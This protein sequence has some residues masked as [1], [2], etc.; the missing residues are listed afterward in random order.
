[1]MISQACFFSGTWTLGC[2][3]SQC[4]T[5]LITSLSNGTGYR[6]GNCNYT[7]SVVNRCILDEKNSAGTPL[8]TENTGNWLSVSISQGRNLVAN[9]YLKNVDF[10]NVK[11]CQNST[12]DTS[13]GCSGGTIKTFMEAVTAGG[14]DGNIADPAGCATYSFEPCNSIE[15]TARLR[16]WWGQWVYLLIDSGVDTYIMAVPRP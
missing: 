7:N 6:L 15:C 2:F 10:N 4:P 14:V 8:V 9:S 3:G 5:K 11:I 1:M 12:F 13:T 16:P